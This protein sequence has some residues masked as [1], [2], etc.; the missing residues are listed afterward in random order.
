MEGLKVNKELINSPFFSL[1]IPF[2][3]AH[4]VHCQ[5]QKIFSILSCFLYMSVYALMHGKIKV[6]TCIGEP[7]THTL[8][9]CTCIKIPSKILVLT[10]NHRYKFH[11]ILS[12]KHGELRT[13]VRQTVGLEP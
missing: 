8:I 9:Y 10:M 3:N 6:H 4:Y 1:K 13:I 7:I 11:S 12:K 2:I 5:F